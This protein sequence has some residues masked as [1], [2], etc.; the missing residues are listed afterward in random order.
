MRQTRFLNYP[1]SVQ[2]I[3]KKAAQ[4]SLSRSKIISAL[5]YQFRKS[6]L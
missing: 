2:M 4:Q 3:I 1:F 5:I 6:F